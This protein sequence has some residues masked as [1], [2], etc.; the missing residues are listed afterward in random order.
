MSEE[1]RVRAAVTAWNTGVD[2]FVA[3]LAP[4]VELHPPAGFPD[5]D[6][7]R[8]R[9][10]VAAVLHDMF[11][12]VFNSVTYEVEDMERTPRGW[13]LHARESVEQQR[14]MKLEWTEWLLIEL[15]G[16]LISRLQVFY[17]RDT[18]LKQSGLEV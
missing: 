4:D 18:A 16:E 3:C 5:G 17:D 12:S 7:W 2:E 14:G 9:D 8:G 10:A 15:D 1:Q 11:G 13:L 6:M